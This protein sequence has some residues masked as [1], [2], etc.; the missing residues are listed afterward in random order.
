[1]RPFA[2]LHLDRK[3]QIFSYSPKPLI[4]H[5][6]VR[7]AHI[8]NIISLVLLRDSWTCCLHPISTMAIGSATSTAH[9]TPTIRGS[10]G[11]YGPLKLA[12]TVL[13]GTTLYDLDEKETYDKSSALDFRVNGGKTLSGS[14]DVNT[15]KNAV[16]SLLCASTM[17]LGKTVLR[18]VARIEEVDRVLEVLSSIGVKFRWIKGRDDLEITRPDRLDLTAIDTEAA[19]KTRAVIMLLGPL[20]YQY[21]AFKL[22]HAGGCYLGSRTVEP[23]FAALRQFGL[24]IV[25]TAS[26]YVTKSF[27]NNEKR[28]RVILIERGDTVTEN[29]LM[30]AAMSQSVTTIVNASPNYMV[31]DLC[32]FLQELGVS[33]EGVGTTTL[34]VRG[35]KSF[36][37]TVDYTISEDPI[38]AM[39][40][41]AA[42]IVTRS[43]ITIQRAPIEFLE[44][45][46]EI[47]RE[48][49]FVYRLST[50]Y[51]SRNKHTRLVDITTSASVIHAPRDKIHSMPFPGLNTDNLPFFAVIAAV[52]EG[53]TMI[54]D[55]VYDN[56]AIYLM[57]LAQLN[58]NVDFLDAHRVHI[59]G[60]TQ[61]EAKEIF[62][63]PAL[64]PTVIIL[65]A[66]LAVPG[67]SILRNANPILR[68]YEDFANRLKTLGAN[69]DI[70]T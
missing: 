20:I 1:M 21:K 27:P 26:H 68:G 23:H 49:G 4:F 54:H 9:K 25:T 22:P 3:R 19:T 43:Q 7:L 44:I 15:S 31:Q 16:V 64:R 58:A 47:L 61:W 62:A 35:E 28:R 50:E 13:E 24:E 36:R 33:I 14:I 59:T 42:A 10:F 45:E 67:S 29:V 60:P 69:I 65:I 57:K 56:R 18:Q 6:I 66:M 12:G 2:N 30:A 8:R 17:N 37:R 40:L 53:R 38:E 39:S 70:L 46:L 32:L 41:I 5:I 55:W 63:P 11:N 52:A 48:M 34:I 51:L